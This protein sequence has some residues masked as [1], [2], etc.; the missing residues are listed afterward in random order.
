M[1]GGVGPQCVGMRLG[2]GSTEVMLKTAELI[3]QVR[4]R[5]RVAQS[6]QKSYVD[7]RRS[8]LEFQVG[9]FVLLNVSP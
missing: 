6:H 4:D 3:Q 5:L 9:D 1:V 8:N 2:T 7:R